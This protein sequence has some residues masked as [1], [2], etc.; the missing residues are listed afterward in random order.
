MSD[1]PKPAA[2]QPPPVYAGHLKRGPTPE[3][4]VGELRDQF[5]WEIHIEGVRDPRG[6]G[7]TLMG[8]VGTPPISLRQPVIDGE[9]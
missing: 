8:R 5:G 7:Y 2:D 4:I 1:A 3:T 6:G 9:G